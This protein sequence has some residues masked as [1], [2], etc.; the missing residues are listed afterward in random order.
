MT[1]RAPFDLIEE[2]MLTQYRRKRYYP[3]KIGDVLKNQ[4]KV[5]S[6]LGYGEYSTVW[7]AWDERLIALCYGGFD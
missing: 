6:K 1:E 7:L 4:Y 3:V 5:I 2:Q